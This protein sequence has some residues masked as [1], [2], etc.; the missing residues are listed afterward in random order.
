MLSLTQAPCL[1]QPL[2]GE[3]VLN[4]VSVVN[5]DKVCTNFYRGGQPDYNALQQLKKAGVKVDICL[6]DESRYVERESMAAKAA[7]LKFVNIPLNALRHPTRDDIAEFI[8]VVG[9]KDKEPVYVHCVH[10]RDRTGTMVAIYR[11]MHDGWTP[12][13]AYAEMLQHGFRPVLVALSDTVYNVG[14]QLGKNGHRPT[15]S[16]VVSRFLDRINR[17]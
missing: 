7:G 17:I 9:E 5:L 14:A 8:H 6:D 4:R 16:S 12:D 13:A 2:D 1:S 11:I 10:G 15:L 3:A